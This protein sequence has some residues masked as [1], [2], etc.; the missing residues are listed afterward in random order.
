M[1][2]TQDDMSRCA[3]FI[4]FL[5]LHIVK[6]DV[7]REQ[8]VN[9]EYQLTEANCYEAKLKYILLMFR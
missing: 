3:F 9:T 6:H 4:F 7:A 5:I 2:Y 8:N 1:A